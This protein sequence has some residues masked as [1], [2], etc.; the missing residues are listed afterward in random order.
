MAM[1]KGSE[2][3]I[4]LGSFQNRWSTR[5]AFDYEVLLASE[6]AWIYF[7]MIHIMLGR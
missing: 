5:R 7:A 6:E 3:L 1:R 4:R 2:N